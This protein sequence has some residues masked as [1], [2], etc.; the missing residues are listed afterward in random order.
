[1]ID[2]QLDNLFFLQLPALIYHTEKICGP[3]GI[4]KFLDILA[5]VSMYKSI[6]TG[7]VYGERNAGL[8]DQWNEK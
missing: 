2:V 6:S 7:V 8:M 1:V 3:G 5:M 4:E